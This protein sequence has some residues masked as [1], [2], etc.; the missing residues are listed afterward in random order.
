MLSQATSAASRNAISLPAL[1]S[2]VWPCVGRDGRTADLFGLRHVPA[3]LSARQARELGLMTSGTSGQR[4]IGSSNSA[5]LQSSLESRLQ[6]KTQTL[7]STLYRLT[8]KP[9]ITQ[10]GRSRFRLRASVL[11]TSGTGS[12]GWPALPTPTAR[13]YR[14]RYSVSL[15]EARKLHPRG[16][17]LSEFMQRAFGRPGYLNPELPR[18]LMG[19]PPEWCE[20]APT[21]TVSALQ[22]RRHSSKR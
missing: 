8:W 11:R 7:G 16:V 2:G 19:L 15:L 13:D 4:S 17:P 21:E 9:W 22:R 20:S 6:A 18:L 12:T 10:S 1:E 5:A 3:N 14:G